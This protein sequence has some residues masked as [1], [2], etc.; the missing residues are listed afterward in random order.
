MALQIRPASTY[1]LGRKLWVKVAGV[2]RRVVWMYYR[3]AA[4]VVIN[5][6]YNSGL[7][8]NAF[9]YNSDV[10]Q[11]NGNTTYS[12][13]GSSTERSELGQS[14]MVLKDAFFYNLVVTY[15][16]NNFRNINCTVAVPGADVFPLPSAV[17]VTIYNAAG[18][19]LGRLTL[20][21]VS[22]NGLNAR[23]EV[24]GAGAAAIVEAARYD[25]YL[26][27]PST[28]RRVAVYF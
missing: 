24:T 17:T 12:L 5:S 3:R 25:T 18:N 20:P 9:T 13:S 19:S 28:T 8:V 14:C 1:K 16:S 11:L 6:N 2:W 22:N 10:G 26:A 15:S 7:E 4:G 21:L 23:Y 27:S